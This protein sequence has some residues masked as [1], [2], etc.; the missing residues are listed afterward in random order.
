MR[1]D[2]TLGTLVTATVLCLVCSVVVATAASALRPGIEANEEQKRQRNVLVAAGLFDPSTDDESTV[3]DIYEDRIGTV[4]VNLE[5]GRVD[6]RTALSS[7]DPAAA[8]EKL[9]ES[10]ETGG[11]LPG[12]ERR[13][14]KAFAY[15]VR[16]EN[17]PAA[18]DKVVLPVYGYGLWSTMYG[19][20]ALEKDCNTIAGLTFYKHA[21]TPGL[22]GE[23][24]N[25]KWK[26]DWRNKQAYDE[27]GVPNVQV[28]KGGYDRNSPSA[29][30]QVDGLSGA[31]ITS[32][33]V[34]NSLNYWLGEGGF[35]PFLAKV[36]AG[37]IAIPEPGEGPDPAGNDD[38]GAAASPEELEGG[39]DAGIGSEE[40]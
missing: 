24:D 38:G 23:I 10:T 26:A 15:L 25:D 17:D 20:L 31:T 40:S 2:T 4:L 5:D 27:N 32:K 6:A 36:R 37:E 33:G 3:T 30:Y 13:E 22:G 1:R 7:Y 11:L 18:I 16:D 21:E 12:W 34:E 29:T 14:N 8:R 39:E 19:Y 28:V 9:D 35:G